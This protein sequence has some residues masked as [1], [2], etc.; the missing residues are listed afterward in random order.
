MRRGVWPDFHHGLAS[1]GRYDDQN[2]IA[3]RLFVESPAGVPAQFPPHHSHALST[4]RE[5][6]R[7]RLLTYFIT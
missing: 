3:R 5:T 2:L 6:G 7:G 4:D 1:M